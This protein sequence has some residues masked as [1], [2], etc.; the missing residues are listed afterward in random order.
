MNKLVV[1]ATVCLIG[2]HGKFIS[3]SKKFSDIE[4]VEKIFRPGPKLTVYKKSTILALSLR[5]FVDISY[6]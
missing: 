1:L 2:A 3:F 5:N 6:L 4:T